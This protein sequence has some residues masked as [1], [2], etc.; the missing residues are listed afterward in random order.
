MADIGL[1]LNY[2]TSFFN[3]VYENKLIAY[4]DTNKDYNKYI[5]YKPIS[6]NYL[7]NMSIYGMNINDTDIDRD[8]FYINEYFNN[9]YS[10]DNNNGYIY[11][12]VTILFTVFLFILFILFIFRK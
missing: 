1:N 4:K 12:L 10:I 6:L 9:H 8:N 3:K 7:R 2:S 11:R 5:I